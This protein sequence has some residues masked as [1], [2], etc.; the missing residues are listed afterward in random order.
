MEIYLT[1]STG[2]PEYSTGVPDTMIETD[3][4]VTIRNAYTGPIM[5]Q[6]NVCL[7]VFER[8][9]HYEMNCWYGSPDHVSALPEKSTRAFISPTKVGLLE[10]GASINADDTADLPRV[11]LEIHGLKLDKLQ[12]AIDLYLTVKAAM[13]IES[14]P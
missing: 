6:G 12:Q 7:A 4:Y 11:A 2:V 10:E 9:G 1:S 3:Q 5:V 13:A 8:N 14:L